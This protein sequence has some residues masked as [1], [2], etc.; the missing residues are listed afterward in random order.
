VIEDILHIVRQQAEEVLLKLGV[1]DA[2]TAAHVADSVLRQTAYWETPM[3]NDEKLVFVRLFSPV[4]QR[5]E[6]FLG[7]ILLND[8]LSKTFVRVI[9][10]NNLGRVELVANDLQNYYFLIRTAGTIAAAVDRFSSEVERSLPDLF[11]G[12]HDETKGIYGDLSRMFTFRK[13]E[14][15][16]FPVYAIPEFLSPKL[17]IAIRQELSRLLK[18]AVFGEQFRTVLA[19]TA[20][21]YGR[22][23]GGKGDV[24][25]PSNFIDHLVNDKEYDQI[26]IDEDVKRAFNLAA[27]TKATIK[28]SIDDG[29]YSEEALRAL[30]LKITRSFQEQIDAGSTKWLMAFLHHD[31]KFLDLTSSVYISQILAYLQIGVTVFSD[32]EGLAGESFRCTA[33]GWFLSKAKSSMCLMGVGAFDR[34]NQ[35]ARQREKESPRVCVRCALY[36]Y[37]GQKLLGTEAVSIGGNPPKY[38]QVPKSYNLVFHYG[39]HQEDEID[40]VT[41][42]LDLTWDLLRQKQAIAQIRG[43]VR[44][45]EEQIQKLRAQTLPEKRLELQDE[46][47]LKRDELCGVEETANTTGRELF[48]LCPWLKD[49]DTFETIHET[50]SLDVLSCLQPQTRTERYILGL[51]VGGYRVIIFVLPQIRAPRAAK[52]RDFAQRRFSNSRVTVS[53]ILSFFRELCGC[54]GPFYYQSLPTL[55]PDAFNRQ[56]FYIRNDPISVE[57]AQSEYE[58]VTQLAW[59]LVKRRKPTESGAELFTRKVILAEQLLAD[60]LGTFA[61]VMRDSAIL[62]RTDGSYKRLPGGYRDDWKAEDLTEYGKF[63]QR[64]SEIQE[65][66]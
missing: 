23:S 25:S 43:Q 15:E 4:V 29:S 13:S 16:P 28:Q 39:R 11:F 21:F 42:S 33:C 53:V 45:L 22:K 34:H 66:R 35:S 46:I 7:N 48:D 58:L 8:F 59:K 52:D 20:F 36:S 65:E 63:I 27:V 44:V 9:A 12:D 60:P 50:P 41:K 17:E 3:Q 14:F 30:L 6:V 31:K 5:E 51:G 47:V 26:I 61:A 54:D 10:D 32:V 38:A 64:L 40:R 57:K 18:P 1:Q 19:A 56:T 55:T 37:L 62:G 2:V 49:R 24:Q